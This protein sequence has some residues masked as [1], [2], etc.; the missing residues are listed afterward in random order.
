MRIIVV[1]AGEVGSYVAELLSKEGN[2]VAIIELDPGRLGEVERQLDVHTIV[3]NGTHPRVLEDAGIEDA[4]LLV[5]VTSQ[6][7][8]NLLSCLVAKQAGVPRTIARIEAPDL[9]GRSATSI[10]K[11]AGADKVI[12]PDEA[13]ARAIL[14]LLAYPGATAIETLGG[15]EVILIGAALQADAPICGQTLGEIGKR[16]EPDWDFIVGTITRND[17]TIIPRSD[18]RL[19]A[20]DSLQVLCKRRARHQ[21]AEQLG[22]ERGRHQRLMLLGGGRTAEM[23]ARW[24]V[25]E[26]QSEVSLI[27]RDPVRARQLAEQLDGLLVLQGDITDA[28]LLASEEVGAHDA[29]IALTGE[30]DANILACLYAKSMGA[31]ETIAVLHRLEL[32]GLLS[33]VGIDVALSPRTASA[34]AVLEF[35]RGGLTQVAR[36]LTSDVEVFEVEVEENSQAEDAIVAELG[37]PRDTLIAAVVRDGKPEIGRKWSQFRER[38]H[39]IVVSKSEKTA[40]VR[41]LFARS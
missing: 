34:N 22:L 3:G 10:H 25:E 11:A 5:A 19:Q 2:N 15:G 1:G 8:V 13:T 39:V 16:Y 12:D 32:R 31:R 36:S 20:G 35:V 28:T 40:S 6:D 41:Q 9:R 17:D 18:H 29:V 27:E 26:R 14:G 21:V 4:D 24:L 7:S 30:D 37:L 23:L 33:E 38:D